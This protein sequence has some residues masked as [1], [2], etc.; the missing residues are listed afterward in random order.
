MAI[1][2]PILEVDAALLNPAQTEIDV[3]PYLTDLLKK[4]FGEVMVNSWTSENLPVF[5]R[6]AARGCL[7][8]SGVL[9]VSVETTEPSGGYIRSIEFDG[10]HR[11]F[12]GV[13][14][15]TREDIIRV[16]GK[17][18]VDKD[19]NFIPRKNPIDGEVQT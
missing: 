13:D 15:A 7:E 2:E 14:E 19:K 8:R 17:P 11:H 16:L 18:A 4:T 9:L 5:Y 10:S 1:T 3:V 12:E 6:N